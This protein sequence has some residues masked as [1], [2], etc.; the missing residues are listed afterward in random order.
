MSIRDVPPAVRIQLYLFWAGMV[1]AGIGV[2]GFMLSFWEVGSSAAA[3]ID[4]HDETPVLA[5]ASIAAW[6]AG[7]GTMWWSRRRL[8][9]A[10]AEK[11]A[12]DQAGLY[13]DLG[14]IGSDESEV[15]TAAPDG[16]DS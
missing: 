13:V 16:R 1:I 4:V 8:E 12:G 2:V 9:A 15:S 3:V 5:Y 10:V 11:Y 6:I 7:L 14:A